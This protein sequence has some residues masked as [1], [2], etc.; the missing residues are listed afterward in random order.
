MTKPVAPA[1]PVA[2]LRVA[3]RGDRRIPAGGNAMT[4][5]TE[6]VLTIGHANHAPEVFS[7]L[8]ARHRVTAVADVRSVPYSRRHPQFNREALA[9]TLGMAGVRYVCLGRELGG[10]PDDRS[11]YE[12]GRVRYDRLAR[13]PRFRDGLERVLRGAAAYR[14][15]LM[16]AEREPL[17][18]HR[19][20][21]VG[22]E[23]DMRGVDVAHV[24]PDATLESHAR[25]M[26]RLLAEFGLD[27]DEDLFLPHRR[28][29]ERVREAIARR[30]GHAG[31]SAE[32]VDA[33][34]ER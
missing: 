23:L 16:C 34:P 14:I 5:N 18:C 3:R 26:D 11:C 8:L 33:P 10:R 6:T 20:L 32:R 25:A 12:D 13:T 31:R 21:L 30:T 22:Q 17:H 19:T 1:D 15:A 4:G 9:R 7:G 28:R 29:D 27:A 2:S 24:L